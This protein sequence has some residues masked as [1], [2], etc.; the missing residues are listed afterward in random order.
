MSTWRT[1]FETPRAHEYFDEGELRTLI[2]HDLPLWPLSKG[3]QPGKER[4]LTTKGTLTRSTFATTRESEFFTETELG[5][6]FGAP[7]TLWPLMTVKELIDNALDATEATD[8]PPEIAITLEQDSIVVRDNGPGLPESTVDKALNYNLRVS[9]K[10]HY[11]AP[12]RGQLGNAL[13]CIIP[14]AYVATEEKSVVEITARGVHHRIEVDVDRI[15]NKPRIQH[16]KTPLVQNGTRI[17][18]RW[19][20]VACSKSLLNDYELYRGAVQEVLPD[21]VRDFASI[22]PHARFTVTAAGKTQTFEASEPTWRKWRASDPTSP[23]WYGKAD[24]RDLIAAYIAKEEE[25][26]LPRKTLRDFVGEFDGLARPQYRKAV[27]ERA[28]LAGK[29]LFD[30]KA[31]V[32][33]SMELTDRLLRA[34]RSVSKPVKPSR[35]GF[36]GKA[37][38]QSALAAYGA[39]RGVKYNRQP[40]F[41]EDGLPYVVEVGFGISGEGMRRKLICGLNHSVLFQVPSSNLYSTLQEC[42]LGSQEPVVILVHQ[43]HPHFKFTGHGKG[44]L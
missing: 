33:G 37:H 34:M 3:C 8:V 7:K 19:P 13:K 44:S 32:S 35:L 39:D 11:I 27:L 21:L 17:T 40:E 14:A 22:N 12:S 30:L 26:N 5:M 29:Y 25:E 9:D 20:N 1:T 31:D 43:S 24:L 4:N 18:V 6:Q 10:R 2:G 42:W 16:V 36:I 28:G 41:G 38:M 15:T 23:H